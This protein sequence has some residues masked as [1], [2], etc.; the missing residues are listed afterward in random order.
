MVSLLGMMWAQAIEWTYMKV[1]GVTGNVEH[2]T[3]K[4]AGWIRV[5]TFGFQFSKGPTANATVDLLKVGKGL[6]KATP[7][8][9]KALCEGSQI[10]SIE[11]SVVRR[12]DSA[13]EEFEVMVYEL[14]DTRLTSLGGTNEAASVSESTVTV[15]E[16]I[17]FSI[18][19]I[20]VTYIEFEYSTGV[21]IGRSSNGWDF[22]NN[23]PL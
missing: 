6:D 19:A 10:P 20:K 12:P 9:F 1:D 23:K 14:L 15:G 16:E 3:R 13:T 21:E 4:E 7:L 2:P 11:V 17:D 18:R 5:D 8:L 22:E